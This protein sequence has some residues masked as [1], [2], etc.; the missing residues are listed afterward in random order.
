[1][2]L[3]AP[4]QLRDPLAWGSG[5]QLVKTVAAVV[6]AWVLADR[7][8]HLSQSFLAP[9]AAL[10]TVQA[11]VFGSL[12]HGVQQV[13]ATVLGVLLAFVAGTIFGV[14][15]LSIG[16]AVFLGLAAG[17]VRGL[18]SESTTAAA[19]ALVVLTTGY[20]NEAG[21]LAERL[22]GTGIGVAIGLLVNVLLWPPL[23]DRAAARRVGLLDD[24]IGALLE[25]VAAAL[26]RECSSADVDG[27][28]ERT[29]Q[30]DDAVEQAGRG[31]GQARESGRLNPRPAAPG[32]M[33]AAAGFDEVLASLAQSVADTR[34]MIRTIRLAPT[35]PTAWPPGFREPWLALLWRAGQAV[36]QAD[37]DAVRTAQ[38]DLDAFADNL[39]V[40]T[41]PHDFWPVSGALLMD[42]R[43]ILAGLESVA[44]AQ[45]LQVP[46]PWAVRRR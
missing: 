20:E 43:N 8:L 30:L 45:P 26:G 37:P 24:E 35:A 15:A 39:D 36:A 13:G 4:H 2:R 42:L 32:R 7:V 14:S 3:P 10:L 6:I 31:L 44:R 33:R 17:G 25:R 27:W 28:V 22:L 41:L 16:V 34:S 1:M 19:T 18:R 12:K 9:W 29:H 40:Q 38:A 11:T 21:L 23:R 46:S 5:V